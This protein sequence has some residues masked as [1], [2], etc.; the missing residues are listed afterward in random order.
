MSWSF[1]FTGTKESVKASVTE[2][3]DKAAVSYAGKPEADD[4][5]CVKLRVCAL[6]DALVLDDENPGV[7]ATGWGS[8]SSQT[9]G[10]IAAQAQ[11]AVNRCVLPPEPSGS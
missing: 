2:Y 7:K 10:P 8:H 11:F 3:C 1:G 4:V 6:V 5:H 9:D